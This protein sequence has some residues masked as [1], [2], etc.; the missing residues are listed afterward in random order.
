MEREKIQYRGL[1]N[2]EIVQRILDIEKSGF[3]FFVSGL[4]HN[5]YDSE[6]ILPH[7]ESLTWTG[8]VKRLEDFQKNPG[9]LQ[10]VKG[11]VSNYALAY[12]YYI[13]QDMGFKLDIANEHQSDQ[14]EKLYLDL[15]EELGPL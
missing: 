3:S 5:K 1:T 8:L 14:D 12:E 11:G 15:E 4:G 2:E 7:G 10:H 6:V 9:L 13:L